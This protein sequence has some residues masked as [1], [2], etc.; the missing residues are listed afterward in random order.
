MLHNFHHY[1]RR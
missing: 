1:L